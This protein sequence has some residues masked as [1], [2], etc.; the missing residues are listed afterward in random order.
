MRRQGEHREQC[1]TVDN[2]VLNSVE[3]TLSDKDRKRK[4]REYQL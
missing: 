4:T 2:L 3:Q 1:K